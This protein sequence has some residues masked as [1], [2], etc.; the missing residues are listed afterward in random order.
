MDYN[1]YQCAFGQV[2]NSIMTGQVPGYFEKQVRVNNINHRD[3]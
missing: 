1:G 3:H 2:R